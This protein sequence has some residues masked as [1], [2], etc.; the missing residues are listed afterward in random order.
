MC[1][2]QQ[3][4]YRNRQ[5]LLH[6]ERSKGVSELTCVARLGDQPRS[7]TGPAAT[8]ASPARTSDFARRS[9]NQPVRLRASGAR[10]RRAFAFASTAARRQ[11]PGEP[12]RRPVRRRG[13]L[14]QR[15]CSSGPAARLYRQRR[16][17]PGRI[18]LEPRRQHAGMVVQFPRRRPGQSRVRHIQRTS[19]DAGVSATSRVSGHASPV[20]LG[21]HWIRGVSNRFQSR[22]DVAEMRFR[23]LPGAF[24]GRPMNGGPTIRT[25]Q[26][27]DLVSR[28][29]G[30]AVAEV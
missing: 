25:V 8:T 9:T 24:P 30:G 11:H 29:G 18:R 19:S 26:G 6:D 1:I 16:R 5:C 2:M 28:V 13:I 15:R 23:F 22:Q 21:T 20:G 12:D 17:R 14:A 7:N 4:V 10:P 3:R 27:G